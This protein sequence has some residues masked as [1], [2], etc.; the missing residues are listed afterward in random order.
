[1]NEFWH[2][3]HR[4]LAVPARTLLVRIRGLSMD[5]SG[6]PF[7][8]FEQLYPATQFAFAISGSTSRRL[9]TTPEF[10]HWAVRAMPRTGAARTGGRQRR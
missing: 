2:G 4:L 7:D 6:T 9:F 5:T 8:C 3:T 1:M 10:Q